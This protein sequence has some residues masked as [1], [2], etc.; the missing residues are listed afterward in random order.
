MELRH[1]LPPLLLAGH[2]D[3][4]ARRLT[5]FVRRFGLDQALAAGEDPSRD[6]LLACRADQLH[7]EKPRRKI[8][9]ALR[10][11]VD[12]ADRPASLRACVPVSHSV[13]AVR[14]PLLILAA[15]LETDPAVGIRGVALANMLVTDSTSPLFGSSTVD[16]LEAATDAALEGLGG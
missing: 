13:R 12:E 5:A 3:P 8:A 1:H 16:E 15:R 4:L 7:S 9:G 11:A 10:R 6:D 2:G 14:A